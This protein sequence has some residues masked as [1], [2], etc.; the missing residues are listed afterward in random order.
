MYPITCPG[1][2]PVPAKSGKFEVSGFCV[3]VDDP[4]ADS[5]FA[6]VDDSTIDQSGETG[7]LLTTL[8]DKKGVLI[9]LKGLANIDNVLAYGF[10]EPIKTRYGL[11]I[12]GTNIKS[13]SVCVYRR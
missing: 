7:K 4:T 12:Y 3:T 11:S 5:A 2:Y 1:G 13:G 10:D 9:Y 8:T 6:L